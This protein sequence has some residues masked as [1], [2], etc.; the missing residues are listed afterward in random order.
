MVGGLTILSLFVFF[1]FQ[2]RFGL[3]GGY[4][5]KHQKRGSKELSLL[6]KHIGYLQ[7]FRCWWKKPCCHFWSPSKKYNKLVDRSWRRS[8]F[9][10]PFSLGN[11]CFFHP[12]YAENNIYTLQQRPWKWMVERRSFP[13]G[14]A[15]FQ[16]Q[17]VCFRECNWFWGPPAQLLPRLGLPKEDYW[18]YRDLRCSEAST[19][20]LKLET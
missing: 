13:F 17:T 14:M 15:Y 7:K 2:G 3:K 4:L 18:W 19:V 5:F 11:W 9:K 6:G 20:P 8:P 10:L 1:Y 16:V 12:T